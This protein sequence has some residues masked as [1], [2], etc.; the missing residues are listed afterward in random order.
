MSLVGDQ[1]EASHRGLV[2]E[3]DPVEQKVRLVLTYQPWLV[4]QL[5]TEA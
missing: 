2:A 5:T 1:A 3:R 4:C